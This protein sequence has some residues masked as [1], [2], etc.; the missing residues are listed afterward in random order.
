[1][2]VFCDFFDFRLCICIFIY[3]YIRILLILFDL[4]SAFPSVSQVYLIKLLSK[5]GLPDTALNLIKALYH[6]N[7]GAEGNRSAGF[8]MSAGV[9]QGCPLS[10]LLYALCADLLLERIRT[11]LPSALVRAYADD[12]AV[13]VQNLWTDV[14]ILAEIFSDFAEISNLRL[15]FAKTVV[16]PL[17]P[18][19]G[20]EQ[21]RRRLATVVP[22]WMEVSFAYEKL[23]AKAGSDPPLNT[24]KG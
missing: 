3:R 14:P 8:R 18:Q 9:R 5:L 4:S 23:A 17:F 19:P 6:N 12:T 13:L 7:L 1:M 24:K 16:V 15:N 2:D 21:T 20:I 10:P 11:L 22:T